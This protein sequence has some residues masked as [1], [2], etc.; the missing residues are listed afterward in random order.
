MLRSKK[1]LNYKC[2]INIK[3]SNYFYSDDVIC[4]VIKISNTDIEF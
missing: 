4:D 3:L 1:I 2:F